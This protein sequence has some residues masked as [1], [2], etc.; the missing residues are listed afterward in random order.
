MLLPG[1][2]FVAVRAVSQCM[3]MNFSVQLEEIFKYF[4]AACGTSC[5]VLSTANYHAPVELA[6]L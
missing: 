5:N 3:I 2:V 1:F 6:E 4:D